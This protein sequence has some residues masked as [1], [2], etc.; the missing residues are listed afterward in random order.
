MGRAL[1]PPRPS[2]AEKDTGGSKPSV[3]SPPHRAFR[4]ATKC[5]RSRTLHPDGCGVCPD[6][7]RPRDFLEL[8]VDV[9]GPLGLTIMAVALMVIAFEAVR[10]LG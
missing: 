7:W 1:H 2:P 9:F 5:P 3:P 8:L 10:L 6:M 4:F